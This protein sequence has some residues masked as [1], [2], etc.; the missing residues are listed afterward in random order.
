MLKKIYM[1]VPCPMHL[2][3]RPTAKLAYDTGRGSQCRVWYST[4]KGVMQTLNITM[5][6]TKQVCPKMPLW[7]SWCAGMQQAS[8]FNRDLIWSRLKKLHFWT[9]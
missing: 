9:K 7:G 2:A 6:Q 4:K 8:F 1:L 5:N 3:L